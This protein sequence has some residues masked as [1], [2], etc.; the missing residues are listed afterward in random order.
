MLNDSPH[1]ISILAHRLVGSNSPVSAARSRR[2][3]PSTLSIPGRAPEATDLLVRQAALVTCIEVVVR[4]AQSVVL[5]PASDRSSVAETAI[6]RLLA[7][8]EPAWTARPA[9]NH[10]GTATAHQADV[11]GQSN[12]G[13]TPDRLGTENAGHRCRK[14]HR[15]A[16]QTQAPQTALHELENLSRAACSRTR[17]DR[18][19]C[20]AYRQNEDPVCIGRP[21][22]RSAP[23][24]PFQRHR[25]SN[26]SM[27]GAAAY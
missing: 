8:V 10:L 20:R 17:L 7:C 9:E 12:V 11:A 4:L 19:L 6:S 23:D 14:I 13:L 3:P 26:G 24:C 1:S 5:C 15:R 25:T 21:G 27:D 22:S 18:L 2:T 16:V